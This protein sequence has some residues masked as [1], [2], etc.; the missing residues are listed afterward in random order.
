MSLQFLPV[1]H[2]EF[3]E[4]TVFCSHSYRFTT[5]VGKALHT[6]VVFQ[7]YQAYL[8]NDHPVQCEV[9]ALEAVLEPTDLALRATKHMLCAIG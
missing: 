6:M 7:A 5:L 4:E 3:V 9:L 8:L 2:N 1:L